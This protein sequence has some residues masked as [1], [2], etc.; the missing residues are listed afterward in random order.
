MESGSHWFVSLWWKAMS[1]IVDSC[2]L[3]KLN[4]LYLLF[5]AKNWNPT[6][7]FWHKHIQI[8]S[9]WGDW[10]W[11]RLLSPETS[12]H[13]YCHISA[14]VNEKCLS[15]CRRS[16]S[17]TRSPRPAPAPRRGENHTSS[18]AV[19]SD[20][21][22]SH[23]DKDRPADSGRLLQRHPSA[24]DIRK[25]SPSSNDVR[26]SKKSVRAVSPARQRSVSASPER[27]SNKHKRS[28]LV[29]SPLMALSKS[30]KHNGRHR[31]RGRSHSSKE[32]HVHSSAD[33][34]RWRWLT[35]AL[36]VGKLRL[37]DIRYYRPK[38]KCD[39]LSAETGNVGRFDSCWEIDRHWLLQCFNIVGWV[40]C[41]VKSIPEMS[42][43]VEW[44]VKPLLA[45]SIDSKRWDKMWTD[46]V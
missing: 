1:R 15:C 21:R 30:H 43:C 34:R 22:S 28:K 33:R 20:G 23:Y 26:R 6:L 41:H 35:A 19:T 2:S 42:L 46:M 17:S 38:T 32:H 24:A 4:K 37:L 31:R 45:C 39:Y 18:T 36:I 5:H 13:H 12:W 3:T 40:I 8:A 29:S 44:D 10:V 16:R 9:V 14:P 25:Y 27:T 7:R 11:A